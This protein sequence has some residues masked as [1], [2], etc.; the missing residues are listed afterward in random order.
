MPRY[1]FSP[2]EIRAIATLGSEAVFPVGRVY[3]VGRNYADH[4]REMGIDPGRE[5]PFFFLKPA[6]T[7]LDPVGTD[8]INVPYPPATGNLHHEVELVVAIGEGGSEIAAEDAVRHIWGYAVGIDMTR[9][10]LQLAM[11]QAGKP[12]EIGKTFERCAPL[13]AIRPIDQSGEITSG[14]ISLSVGSQSRQSS[15]VANMIWSVNEIISRL[16]RYFVLRPGDLI[17]TGTPEGV[18]AISPGDQLTASIEGV[19]KLH[20]AISARTGKLGEGRN[21]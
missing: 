12:W 5:E 18:G 8:S 17:F 2:P 19:G 10:D 13:S 15:D 20:V 16:S 11:R 7:V 3:C 9:R 6:D 21:G 1:L 14:A 4:A